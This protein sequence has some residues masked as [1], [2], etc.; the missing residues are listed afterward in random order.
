M[1][2][3]CANCL[4]PRTLEYEMVLSREAQPCAFTLR[5]KWVFLRLS[6]RGFGR[7]LSHSNSATLSIKGRPKMVSLYSPISTLAIAISLAFQL[8]PPRETASS[9]SAAPVQRQITPQDRADIFM[10]RKM[11]RE[12]IEMYMQAPPSAL[13]M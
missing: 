1:S 4:F 8:N 12:A 2:G 5:A 9:D 6:A 10:A 11:Y 3:Q 13:M 7:R